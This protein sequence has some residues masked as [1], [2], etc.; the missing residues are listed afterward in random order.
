[1]NTINN[2]SSEVS[3]ASSRVQVLKGSYNAISSQNDAELDSKVGIALEA[4]PTTK[5]ITKI[6]SALNS[7]ASSSDT[8]LREFSLKVGGVHGKGAEV[9]ADLPSAPSLEVLA[10]VEGNDTRSLSA[11]STAL[12]RKFP[13]AEVSKIDSSGNAASFQISFFYKPVNLTILAK[14]DKI[15][16]LS[17]EDTE[18]L[19]KLSSD[20]ER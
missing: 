14:K 19:N 20:N 7:A 6:F 12:E 15:S 1:V 3:D 5:D 16:P 13:L 18:F 17:P 4:L 11:F 9:P 2:L 8:S 10:R